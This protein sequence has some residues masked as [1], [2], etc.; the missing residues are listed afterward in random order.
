MAY[1]KASALYN[2]LHCFHSICTVLK[3]ATYSDKRRKIAGPMCQNHV[4]NLLNMQAL[5]TK[6]LCWGLGNL[7]FNECHR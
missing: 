1:C 7:N 6:P 3:N 4:K 2:I 5:E